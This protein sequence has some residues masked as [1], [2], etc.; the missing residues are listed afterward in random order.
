MFARAPFLTAPLP[1]HITVIVQSST[2]IVQSSGLGNTINADGWGRLAIL[3]YSLAPQTQHSSSASVRTAEICV[4]RPCCVHDDIFT[5]LLNDAEACR[6]Y[7]HINV[8]GMNS[9][10]FKHFNLQHT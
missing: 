2:V 7:V 5:V 1:F 6:I 4:S 9:S 10:L 8:V 3:P